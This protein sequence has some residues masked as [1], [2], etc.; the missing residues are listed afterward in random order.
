MR[1]QFEDIDDVDPTQT[2]ELTDDDLREGADPIPTKFVKFQRVT[3]VTFF[4]EDNSGG[5]VSALGSL[6]MMGRCVMTTNM[7]DFK[8][9]PNGM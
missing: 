6:R 3:S 7:G 4:V 8:K 1:A 2:F 5:E 9:N